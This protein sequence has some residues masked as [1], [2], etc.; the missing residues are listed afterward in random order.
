MLFNQR[1]KELFDVE[2]VTS[3]QLESFINKCG[4]VYRGK[5]YW[6]EDG[7]KTVNFAKTICEELAKLATLNID[8]TLDGGARAKWLQKQ[9]DGV[10]DTMRYWVEYGAGYGTVILKPNGESIDVVLPS[11]YIVTAEK[12]RNIVGTIF[13]NQ[14]KVNKTYYTRFEYHRFEEDGSYVITNKCFKGDSVNDIS[15]PV[16]IE[17]TPWK[18]IDE[19]VTIE[20]LEKPLFAVLSMPN[21]NTID[22]DS[23]LSLPVF[24]NVLGELEDLDVAYSR[25]A[26]EIDESEK[27]V[28]LDSDKLL[29]APL[30]LKDAG[31]TSRQYEEQREKLKLPKY[32][33]NVMGNGATDFYQEINPTLNTSVRIEGINNYLSQIGFKCGFSNGY[34]V[35]NEKTGMITATQVEADDRRTISTVNDVRDR[36][37][38]AIVDLLDAL[39]AFAELYDL[40]PSEDFDAKEWEENGKLVFDFLDFT[41]NVEEDRARWWTYVMAG[42]VPAWKFFVKFEGMSEEEAKEMVDEATPKMDDLM[43]AYMGAE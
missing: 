8:V 21:A 42:K 27:I 7:V 2:D 39:N 33:R 23:P 11:D 40:S 35:F 4:H 43:S 38:K 14:Q 29:P 13:I 3:E 34:F 16:A 15:K 6:L 12:N 18:A 25:N 36:L 10:M 37:K 1:A 17:N 31:Y 28:L 19:E 30:N 5:P 20:G 9:I 26:N 22:V 41:D 32:V 24:N